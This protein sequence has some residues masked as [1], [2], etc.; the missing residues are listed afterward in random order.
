M[1]KVKRYKNKKEQRKARNRIKLHG[2]DIKPR[3][4][5]FKSNKYFYAQV[6]ND[7]INQTM[8]SAQSRNVGSDTMVNQAIHVGKILSEKLQEREITEGVFDKGSYKYHGAV[9]AFV[10]VLRDNNI[11]I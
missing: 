6:I 11:K 7:N 2:T 9:K 10:E 4:S 8:L 1:T 3:I 5:V